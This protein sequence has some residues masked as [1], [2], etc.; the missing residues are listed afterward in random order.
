[1]NRKNIPIKFLEITTSGTRK[2]HRGLSFTYYVRK[3][4]A[5][6]KLKLL[7]PDVDVEKPDEVK[8]RCTI[9][10]I[11]TWRDPDHIMQAVQYA[12]NDVHEIYGILTRLPSV[13]DK[14]QL[15]DYI[16]K[17]SQ[18]LSRIEEALKMVLGEA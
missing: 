7:C 6:D 5:R 4:I 17:I 16:T 18:K 3:S 11:L 1:M 10:A 13:S 12:L 15:L 2:T 9:G 8:R 14:N